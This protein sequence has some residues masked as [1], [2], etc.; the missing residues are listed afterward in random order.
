MTKD[1][2][3]LK[4]CFSTSSFADHLNRKRV[5]SM[6]DQFGESITG[7]I[8]DCNSLNDIVCPPTTSVVT[9]RGYQASIMCILPS[10]QKTPN[11]TELSLSFEK[12]TSL[13]TNQGHDRVLM[14]WIVSNISRLPNSSSLSRSSVKS[15]VS[16]TLCSV[17]LSARNWD[18]VLGALDWSTMEKLSFERTNFEADQMSTLIKR[19]PTPSV[20]SYRMANRTTPP[21]MELLIIGTPLARPE[22]RMVLTRLETRMLQ[23]VRDVRIV[24]ADEDDK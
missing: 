16:L 13:V 11:M 8:L 19:Y 4:F 10:C 5:L 12:V 9:A 23:R 18:R 20:N 22:N 1:L 24:I 6:L 21:L 17:E 7:H 3:D 15:L 14:D 2:K